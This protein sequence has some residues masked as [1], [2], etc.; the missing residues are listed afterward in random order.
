MVDIVVTKCG[1]GVMV[2][3]QFLGGTVGRGII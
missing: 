3:A 2:D 1:G